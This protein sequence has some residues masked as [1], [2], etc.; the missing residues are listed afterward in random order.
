MARKKIQL[1]DNIKRVVTIE[2]E[3]TIGATLGTDVRL[4]NGQVAT[5][6]TF[7]TWLGG[8]LSSSSGSGS[9]G[10]SLSSI[11]TT[12][13]DLAT[14]G[15]QVQRL[16]IGTQDQALR[17]SAGGMPEWRSGAALTKTDDT[18]VTVTLGGAPTTSLLAATSLTLGWTGQLGETRGGTAQSSYLQGDMLYASALNT[19]SKLGIG[20]SGRWLGSSG[21]VPQWNAPAALTR[22][23]DTN[24][25]LTL[26]GSAST[27]LLNAAS[28]TLGWTGQLGETRGG[29]AQ[30]SYLTGDLLYASALNT[31]SKLAIGSSTNVLTVVAGVPAWA[32][33][34]GGGVTGLANPSASVGLTAVNGAATTAMRSDAAPALSQSIAPTWSGSHYF[35]ATLAAPSL[36]TTALNLGGSKFKFIN[37]G[38]AADAKVWEWT[39]AATK[40]T[41]RTVDDA[42]AGTRDGLAFT[43]SGLALTAVDYGNST[44]NPIHT[45]NGAIVSTLSGGGPSAGLRLQA[46]AP[47]MV[48]TETDQ[49]TDEKSWIGIANGKIW[50]IRTVDD[51]NTA[52]RDVISAT[53]GTGIAMASMSYGNSTDNPTHTFNGSIVGNVQHNAGAATGAASSGTYT[54]TLTGVANVTGSAASQAQ[55]IRVGN[56]VTVSGYLT[57]NPTNNAVETK[58]GISLPIASAIAN[59]YECCGVWMSRSGLFQAGTGIIRGDATNDRAEGTFTANATGSGDVYYTFTYLVL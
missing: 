8:S 23:D 30:S 6:A 38:G 10:P 18:N 4:P 39:S 36:A 35:T 55:W 22:T 21:S 24:V 54:P 42:D 57:V 51:A 33:A 28:L 13:G 48:W 19:L 9:S 56:V 53:R 32:A 29:T 58:L 27:A 16:G 7:L 37:S 41:L 50:R 47:A 17:V 15:T 59:N 25:T 45:F 34:P 46:A 44:D 43:R 40:L 12:Q 14:R 3:A 1:A 49:T 52:N 11:L 31:L 5:P 20:A 2:T 26:G